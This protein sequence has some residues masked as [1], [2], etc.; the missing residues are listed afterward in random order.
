MRVAREISLRFVG[1]GLELRRG[2]QAI[3][4]GN[5]HDSP[6]RLASLVIAL[7]AESGR[8]HMLSRDNVA[9]ILWP[10]PDDMPDAFFIYIRVL[11]CRARGVFK[12]VGLT[13]ASKYNDGYFLED[14]ACGRTAADALARA[15]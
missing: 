5:G 10:D 4:V 2:D 11:M 14:I 9:D 6:D 13:I 12:A 7:A 1:R 3:I 15:A 8:G